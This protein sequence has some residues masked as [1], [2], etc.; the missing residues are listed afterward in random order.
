MENQKRISKL[1]LVVLIYSKTVLNSKS[2]VNIKNVYIEYFFNRESIQFNNILYFKTLSET[3]K[4][5]KFVRYMGQI[6]VC[7]ELTHFG[8]QQ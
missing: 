6:I 3:N 7:G 2:Y 4:S 8:F 5:T 1:F